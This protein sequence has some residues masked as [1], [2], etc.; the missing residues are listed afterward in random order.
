MKFFIIKTLA[1]LTLF[2]S[3]IFG[4]RDHLIPMAQEISGIL[5]TG[6]DSPMVLSKNICTHISKK[7]STQKPNNAQIDAVKQVINMQKAH[8]CPDE[9]IEVRDINYAYF[10]AA[11]ISA[12]NN[13]YPSNQERYC[14]ESKAMLEDALR[15]LPNMIKEYMD[16][17]AKHNTKSIPYHTNRSG[18]FAAPSPP[19][20]GTGTPRGKKCS[21]SKSNLDKALDDIQDAIWWVANDCE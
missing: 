3:P 2:N 21:Y 6:D 4:Q 11:I 20:G 10:I 9:L 19:P 5:S 18:L 13:N 14:E 17:W 16:C 8:R 1:L 7:Y 15:K 12:D